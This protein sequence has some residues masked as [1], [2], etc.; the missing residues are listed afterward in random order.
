VRGETWPQVIWQGANPEEPVWRVSE[1]VG[2]SDV[3]TTLR[4]YSHAAA[5]MHQEAAD[6]LDALV[7]AAVG[8]VSDR[9]SPGLGRAEK[10]PAPTRRPA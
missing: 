9:V 7:G 6:T 5:A 1:L 3:A 10:G 2:H 4:V 8:R